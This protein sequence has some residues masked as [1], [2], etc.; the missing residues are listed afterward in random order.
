M[1]FKRTPL[2]SLVN[3]F[4]AGFAGPTFHHYQVVSLV[5]NAFVFWSTCAVSRIF[6]PAGRA[7]L[8]LLLLPVCPLLFFNVCIPTPKMF[9]A[10]LFLIS[11]V[12]LNE[13]EDDL[14]L[15][16]LLAGTAIMAHPSM[17][18][19]FAGVA[20]ERLWRSWQNKTFQGKAVA[21]FTL[22]AAMPLLPWVLHAMYILGMNEAFHPPSGIEGVSS[23][24]GPAYFWSRLTMILATVIGPEAFLRW[25]EGL[26][27]AFLRFH[28]ETWLGGYT[29]FGFLA[30]GFA[31]FKNPGPWK[32]MKSILVAT[33]IGA[34]LCVFMNGV[35][36]DQGQAANL[37]GPLSILLFCLL[38]ASAQEWT[39]QSKLLL[40]SVMALEQAVVVFVLYV[41]TVKA[42]KIYLYLY[43]V[44]ERTYPLRAIPVTLF[45]L[46]TLGAYL[47]TVHSRGKHIS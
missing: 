41:L 34:V 26:G 11:V 42:P 47:F 22:I 3:S 27:D 14:D 29:P 4:Y 16:A 23:F 9:A 43:E 36:D 35:V 5:L 39:D 32:R 7:P 12:L 8:A 2:F 20:A 15:S 45:M 30:L 19:Y 6:V 37:M 31:A 33:L 21:R 17:L 10:A 1:L 18:F 13:R 24:A 25:H 40:G 28:W 38:C 44:D 46:G